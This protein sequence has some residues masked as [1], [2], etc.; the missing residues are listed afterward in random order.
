MLFLVAGKADIWVEVVNKV[1]KVV[2]NRI[3]DTKVSVPRF[4][5]LLLNENN[6]NGK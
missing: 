5:A 6:M 2:N 1:T 3:P 4:K